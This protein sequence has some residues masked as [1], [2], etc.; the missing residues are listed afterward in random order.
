M[1]L[2]MLK[3]P[4]PPQQTV[5]ETSI[6]H[7]LPSFLL[8]LAQRVTR[9]GRQARTARTPMSTKAPLGSFDNQLTLAL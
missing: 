5:P 6:D 9:A 7:R 2:T 8:P 4:S 3:P 1:L